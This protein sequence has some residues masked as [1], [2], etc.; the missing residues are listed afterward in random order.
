MVST[1]LLGTENSELLTQNSYRW[2][3]YGP[4]RSD[5]GKCCAEL[6]RWLRHLEMYGQRV[7]SSFRLASPDVD[8]SRTGTLKEF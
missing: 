7:G 3:V 8:G 2:P 1:D 6:N 4:A 5:R